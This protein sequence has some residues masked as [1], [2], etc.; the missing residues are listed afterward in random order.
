MTEQWSDSFFIENEKKDPV[1]KRQDK[2]K[3]QTWII[4]L[5]G[6]IYALIA[7][8]IA[9]VMNLGAENIKLLIAIYFYG[10]IGGVGVLF[11]KAVFA[12]SEKNRKVLIE[13]LEH[14]RA[15]RIISGKDGNILY[16]N[17]R[18]ERLIPKGKDPSLDNF[19]EL[20]TNSRKM[21]NDM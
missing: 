3:L 12:R 19:S 2:K 1:K 16:S 13:V 10:L 4:F 6:L 17:I 20:F 21:R 7:I 15:A 18:F 9:L 14:S 5:V 8:A 11:M